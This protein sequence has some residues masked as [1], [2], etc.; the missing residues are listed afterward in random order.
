MRKPVKTKSNKIAK[1]PFFKRESQKYSHP[2]PSR[3]FIL[4]V[5]DKYGTPIKKM[6]LLSYYI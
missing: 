4:D 5:M 3:E 2:I 1:D 6:S